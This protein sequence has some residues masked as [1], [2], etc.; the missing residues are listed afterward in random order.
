MA[1][2]T[3][4]QHERET[5]SHPPH[6]SS[7]AALPPRPSG[8]EEARRD[9]AESLGANVAVGHGFS[10]EGSGGWAAWRLFVFSDDPGLEVPETHRGFPVTRRALPLTVRT[11]ES[12]GRRRAEKERE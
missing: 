3:Q 12:W 6:P 7:G 9:L 11:G 5:L 1:K 8:I 4:Q 2:N 10:G